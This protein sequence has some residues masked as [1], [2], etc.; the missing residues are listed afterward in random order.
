MEQTI[1]NYRSDE[2][3]FALLGREFFRCYFGNAPYISIAEVAKVLCTGKVLAWRA[4]FKTYM[5]M[6]R[7]P[8]VKKKGQMKVVPETLAAW[9]QLEFNKRQTRTTITQT[10]EKL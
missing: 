3:D 10:G 4:N 6:G 1:L 5:E 2:N 9:F 7:L 8:Y